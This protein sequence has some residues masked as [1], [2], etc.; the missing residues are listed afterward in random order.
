MKA[1]RRDLSE[2]DALFCF[3]SEQRLNEGEEW[4]EGENYFTSWTFRG[5]AK[6]EGRMGC[7]IPHYD[8][9]SSRNFNDNKNSITKYFM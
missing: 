7:G 2:D 1:G 4:R 9:L 6:V 8:C 3:F 5:D